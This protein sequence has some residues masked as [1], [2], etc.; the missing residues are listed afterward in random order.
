MN[1]NNSIRPHFGGLTLYSLFSWIAKE[2]LG[3]KF[4]AHAEKFRL[5]D[6]TLT[7]VFQT[8]YVI[9]LV[10]NKR[11]TPLQGLAL[12]IISLAITIFVR[13]L[14]PTN[15]QDRES[16]RRW[17]ESRAQAKARAREMDECCGAGHKKRLD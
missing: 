17:I 16:N 7:T 10:I 1:I 4:E 15:A 2:S 12:E 14:W 5:I 3:I 13:C 8:V 11:I 6:L 9:S